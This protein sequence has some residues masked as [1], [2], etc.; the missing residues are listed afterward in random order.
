MLKE[1]SIKCLVSLTRGEGFGLPILEA[2]AAKLPIIATNWSAH[3]EYLSYYIP[4][5]HKMIKVNKSRIDNKI[6][7][8]DCMWAEPLEFDF[9]EKIYNYKKLQ[10]D[11]N[12]ENKNACNINSEKIP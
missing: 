3:T 9:K 4:V 7:V 1:N 12:L 2:A 5:N 6:F 8:K 11:N 10:T